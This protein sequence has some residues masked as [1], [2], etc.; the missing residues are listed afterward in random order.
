MLARST[1]IPLIIKHYD[2]YAWE[3][4]EMTLEEME[5]IR[6]LKLHADPVY[7]YTT[8]FIPR[9]APLLEK[10]TIVNSRGIARMYPA[11]F[12]LDAPRLQKLR[13]VGCGLNEARRVLRP[14]LRSLHVDVETTVPFTDILDILSGLPQLMDLTLLR[15]LPSSSSISAGN[16]S[17]HVNSTVSLPL[18]QRLRL[19]G[20]TRTIVGLLDRLQFPTGTSI[21]VDYYFAGNASA[22]QDLC[23][24]VSLKYYG[25]TGPS[26]QSPHPLHTLR[27]KGGKSMDPI[28][29][30]I[31]K[32]EL[33]AE[34]LYSGRKSTH[35]TPDISIT[36][37]PDGISVNGILSMVQSNFHM[38]GMRIMALERF[39]RRLAWPDVVETMTNTMLGDM[40]NLR[41]LL[42]CSWDAI[43]LAKLLR[44]ILTSG[45]V[46]CPNLTCLVANALQWPWS[47]DPETPSCILSSALKQ[48][49][50]MG[51]SI[52]RLALRA[53][54]NVEG[55]D[56]VL[57]KSVVK[58][59][60]WDGVSL[61]VS[62]EH[63]DEP[64]I[65]GPLFRDINIEDDRG[66]DD[67]LS[68]GSGVEILSDVE[69]QE[70]DEGEEIF[71]DA[72]DWDEAYDES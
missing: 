57:C 66:S 71:E 44:S 49:A 19:S 63:E 30:E 15:L 59:V 32:A 37:P 48:R 58:L 43:D 21:V 28:R 1:H 7:L 67:A 60:D 46:V 10:L 11:S 62:L 23:R 27:L 4:L 54:S 68:E 20:P 12:L 56:L 9:D 29:M 51:A 2:R 36:F 26:S 61:P 14:T 72:E 35:P 47:T 42:I 55:M 8:E 52:E 41:S 13:L 65:L 40:T 16:E 34:E 31:W 39:T 38:A 17:S 22:F 5:R 69:E 24:T 50:E 64:D 70:E 6:V 25:S 33:T 18:L 53:C 45:K 3:S